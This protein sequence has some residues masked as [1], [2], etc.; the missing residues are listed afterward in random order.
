MSTY[1]ISTVS[2]KY[3]GAQPTLICEF[4]MESHFEMTKNDAIEQKTTFHIESL[5]VEDFK[6]KWFFIS[7]VV[8]DWSQIYIWNCLVWKGGILSFDIAWW[9]DKFILKI[10]TKS[11]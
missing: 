5:E 3:I 8:E 11:S 7:P 1:R 4:D 6:D 2:D 10:Y 9:G